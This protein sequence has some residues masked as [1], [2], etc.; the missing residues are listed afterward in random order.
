MSTL[1]EEKPKPDWRDVIRK[2]LTLKNVALAISMLI[3]VGSGA[4]LFMILV[5]WIQFPTKEQNDAWIGMGTII[6]H[7]IASFN[8]PFRPLAEYNSQ[9]L[10]AM[11]TLSALLAHPSRAY[12]FMNAIYLLW[13][14]TSPQKGDEEKIAQRI[15]IVEK[16]FP[17]VVVR[18]RGLPPPAGTAKDPQNLSTSAVSFFW[19]IIILNLNCIFQYPLAACMWAWASN[20]PARPGAVVYT[21]LVLSFSCAMIAVIWLVLIERRVKRARAKLSAIEIVSDSATGGSLENSGDC[22]T[23][24]AREGDKAQDGSATSSGS[25]EVTSDNV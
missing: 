6:F 21:F 16:A 10:N 5:K 24:V 23:L 4:F 11:F 14:N 1:S 12:H 8:S 15:E 18:P 13:P 19:I 17:N 20:Y 2:Q 25:H 7:L 9:I 3:I 22:V